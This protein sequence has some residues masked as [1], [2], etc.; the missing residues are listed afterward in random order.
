MKY[1]N[2]LITG[3]LGFIG[4]NLTKYLMENFKDVNIRLLDKYRKNHNILLDNYKIKDITYATDTFDVKPEGIQFIQ[5]NIHNKIRTAMYGIDIIVHLAAQT[6]VQKSIY[7]PIEDV[8]QNIE[9][10]TRILQE[11]R[12]ESVQKI[13]FAS[14]GAVAG[15]IQPP[16]YEKM[17]TMPISPYGISKLAGEHYC[18]VFSQ[19][20]DMSC[21]VLRFSNVY[22][23]YSLHKSSVIARFIGSI[24]SNMAVPS[25]TINGDGKQTRD[26]I[27]VEDLCKAIVKAA[28]KDMNYQIFQVGTGIETSV[29]HLA[30]ILANM[31]KDIIGKELTVNHKSAM[32]GEIRRNYSDIS[33]AKNILN[34]YPS[35]SLETGIRKT[36]EFFIASNSFKG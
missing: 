11:S 36:F 1:K 27:Y 10:T 20:Y 3:G 32:E 25:I 16:M 8:R 23:P 15:N 2:W 6:S 30:S 35:T 21:C 7:D 9:N 22:G 24:L 18:R 13:I 34:W 19:L 5:G 17:D 29:N 33:K 4:I 31:T 28:D 14:S 26:F 12:F